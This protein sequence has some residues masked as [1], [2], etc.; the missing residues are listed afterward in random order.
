V[1]RQRALVY[2]ENVIDGLDAAATG[3][4][5][6]LNGENIGKTLVRL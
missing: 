2:P 5:G 4:I 1:A 3:F 6:M